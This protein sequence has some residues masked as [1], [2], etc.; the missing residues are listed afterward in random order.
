MYAHMLGAY[1]AYMC[2]VYTHTVCVC[3][4]C[5]THIYTPCTV[6]MSY[7]CKLWLYDICMNADGDLL[8]Y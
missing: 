5:A 1:V 6:L 2:W 4:L 3:T 8:I 7:G